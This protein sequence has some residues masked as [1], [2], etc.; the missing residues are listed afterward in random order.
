MQVDPDTGASK[1]KQSTGKGKRCEGDRS[2]RLP[3]GVQRL[4]VC[5]LVGSFAG[6]TWKRRAQFHRA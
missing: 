5:A 4:K 6:M 1:E 3:K 2:L